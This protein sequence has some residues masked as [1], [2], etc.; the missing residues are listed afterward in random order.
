MNIS[1]IEGG[2][3][4]GLALTDKTDLYFVSLRGNSID[5]FFLC[6]NI[7]DI[8][9]F[10]TTFYVMVQTNNGRCIYF[11][12]GRDFDLYLRRQVNYSECVRGW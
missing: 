9:V 10:S 4:F 8:W 12:H 5:I 1:K 6:R 3:G 2:E 7:T 11:G